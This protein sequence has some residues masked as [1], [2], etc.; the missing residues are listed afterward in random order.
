MTFVV[1]IVYRVL[2]GEP[3]SS[4]SQHEVSGGFISPNT[5]KIR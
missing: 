4:Y 5:L 3:N 2:S 1:I